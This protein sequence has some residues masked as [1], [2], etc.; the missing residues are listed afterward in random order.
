[1]SIAACTHSDFL[2]SN[3][4]PFGEIVRPSALPIFICRS[5]PTRFAP[6]A[7]RCASVTALFP[8]SFATC[9]MLSR[10][11]PSA[12]ADNGVLEV[13]PPSSSESS[14]RP[15]L[16]TVVVVPGALV[17]LALFAFPAP[18]LPVNI[19]GILSRLFLQGEVE[20]FEGEASWLV[21]VVGAR[22]NTGE[23]VE[24]LFSA[25]GV[26]VVSSKT[27][28]TSAPLSPVGVAASS[29][30]TAA[31]VV[32]PPPPGVVGSVAV[33]ACAPSRLAL[34]LAASAPSAASSCITISNSPWLRGG[35]VS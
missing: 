10:S 22:F 3:F 4:T 28:A 16:G 5:L 7:T 25:R 1:M 26:E 27:S 2:K 33:L 17:V 13:P 11:K 31:S 19:G 15:A 12:R 18:P 34:V 21:L 6:R 29:E 24:V 30:R 32:V 8:S 20:S 9:S 35:F 14:N 23:D